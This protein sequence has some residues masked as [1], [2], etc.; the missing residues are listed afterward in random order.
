MI[1]WSRDYCGR[2]FTARYRALP[3]AKAVRIVSTRRVSMAEMQSILLSELFSY[4][5]LT[6]VAAAL[7]FAGAHES[8]DVR[9]FNNHVPTCPQPL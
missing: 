1:V 9:I 7:I 2:P 6:F 5:G 3:Q 4:I 8:L